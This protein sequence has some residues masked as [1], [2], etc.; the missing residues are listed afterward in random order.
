MEVRLYLHIKK[1]SSKRSFAPYG[2]TAGFFLSERWL[3]VRSSCIRKGQYYRRFRPV[4]KDAEAAVVAKL[5]K[6]ISCR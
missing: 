2:K 4:G 1:S 5:R 6:S 3:E